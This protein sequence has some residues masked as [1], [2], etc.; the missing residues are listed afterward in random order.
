MSWGVRIRTGFKQRRNSM[1]KLVEAQLDECGIKYNK[2]SGIWEGDDLDE[3][4]CAKQL[5]QVISTIG[6]KSYRSGG[7][8]GLLR[9]VWLY[10]EYVTPK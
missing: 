4:A 10:I 6:D 1:R 8:R 3:T 2:H 9:H 5:A 7:R